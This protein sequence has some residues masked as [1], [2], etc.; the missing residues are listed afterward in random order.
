MTIDHDLKRLRSTDP[1]NLKYD[2]EGV[3]VEQSYDHYKNRVQ[4]IQKKTDR[5]PSNDRQE[6]VKGSA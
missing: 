4:Q 1:K 6:E 3:P 2:M 5:S